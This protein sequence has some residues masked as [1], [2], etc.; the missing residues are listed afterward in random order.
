MAAGGKELKTVR[1]VVTR[2]CY[3]YGMIDDMIIFT[4]DAVKTVVPLTVGQ[5]VTAAVEEDKTSGGLKAIRVRGEDK[6]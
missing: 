3:D 6:L 1:G 5:E 2:F 4:K